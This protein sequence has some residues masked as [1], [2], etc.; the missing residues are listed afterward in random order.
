MDAQPSPSGHPDAIAEAFARHRR[1]LFGL[2]YRM[3]GS[4]AD[5][6]DLLQ[7]TFERALRHA[8]DAEGRDLKPWLVRVAINA[9][10]DHLRRRRAQPYPG[11]WLPGPIETPL[12]APEWQGFESPEA[13]YGRLESV[14]FAFL[15]A[16]EALTPS[17]RAVLLLR[18]VFDLSVRETAEALETTAGAVKTMLH[19]ARSAMATYDAARA[20]A[21]AEHR[22]NAL[23]MLRAYLIHAA[24]G[25]G[26]A[27]R[28][29]LHEDAVL[30]NDGG[31]EFLAGRKP[32][33]GLRRILTFHRKTRRGG[34]P[35][36]AFTLLNGTPALVGDWPTGGRP[37]LARRMVVWVE[38]T[39][40]GRIGEMHWLL[41]SRKLERLPFDALPL[42]SLR[43]VLPA[44]RDALLE[45]P[46]TKWLPAAA[47]RL[48]RAWRGRLQTRD[49]RTRCHSRSTSS[50]GSTTRSLG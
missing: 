45:P 31:G 42:L 17:Q 30:L 39:P 15:R 16:V 44:L 40:D 2:C 27:L 25:N 10:R 46:L 26:D 38:L 32:V 47:L 34:R 48:V 6:E 4:G 1:Y 21:T 37:K 43:D 36:L 41:A 18:D 23:R 13:R 22:A 28:A 11:P 8:P 7:D 3:C 29:L 14:S 20:P 24:T 12:D 5:A 9:C 50:A 35:R 19:R 49:R 33:R